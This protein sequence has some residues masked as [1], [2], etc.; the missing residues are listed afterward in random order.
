MFFS[1]K[2]NLI[3]RIPGMCLIPDSFLSYSKR[4]EN[5]G[6]YYIMKRISKAIIAMLVWI[7]Y[8]YVLF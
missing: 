5:N 3:I 6:C 8:F 2:L 1:K 4:L 7:H